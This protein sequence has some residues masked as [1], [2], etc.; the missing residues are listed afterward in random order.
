MSIFGA[1]FGGKRYNAY[2]LQMKQLKLDEKLARLKERDSMKEHKADDKLQAKESRDAADKIAY[3]NHMNPANRAAG[4][5]HEAAGVVSAGAGL[6]GAIEGG[7][8]MKGIGGMFGGGQPPPG[9]GPNGQ[10]LPPGP[11]DMLKNPMV[12]GGLGLAAILL[13]SKKK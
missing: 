12:L 1:I 13:M 3:E 7:G 8:A 4:I 2:R 5:L 10:P 9:Y 6:V 11:M